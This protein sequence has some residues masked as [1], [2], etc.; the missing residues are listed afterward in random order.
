MKIELKRI[1]DA[2]H[3]EAVN[4]EGQT[5]YMDGS[6]KIGGHNLAMRPMQ[7]VLSA[8]GGCSSIDIISILRKQRQ[9]LEDLRVSIEADR[10]KD[11]TPALFTAIRIHFTLKGEL[12][13][14]KVKRAVDLSM[15]KLCSV[16]L[17]LDKT[18]EISWSYTIV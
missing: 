15:T 11:K 2:Y 3:M 4:E 18:A 14:A 16:K 17:I 13:D 5:T 1:D 8:L 6:P 10:E 7:M 12:Q 9:P